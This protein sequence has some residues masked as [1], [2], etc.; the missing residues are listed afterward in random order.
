MIGQA[1]RMAGFWKPS[2]EV[3]LHARYRN[4]R[5]CVGTT[6]E[7]WRDRGIRPYVPLSTALLP[8]RQRSFFTKR[9]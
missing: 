2:F 8:S 9:L 1:Y 4:F 6:Q 3:A 7:I 5:S